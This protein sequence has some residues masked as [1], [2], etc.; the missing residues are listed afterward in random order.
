VLVNILTFLGCMLLNANLALL[1]P[2]LDLLSG[3]AFRADPADSARSLRSRFEGRELLIVSA[4]PR[5]TRIAIARTEPDATWHLGHI[6]EID[7]PAGFTSA[8]TQVTACIQALRKVARPAAA[9]LCLSHSWTAT[10][11]GPGTPAVDLP[12]MCEE[13][14]PFIDLPL[15]HPVLP[16]RL[17]LRID[18]SIVLQSHAALA[19]AGL[20]I[21]RI[22]IAT[23]A[24]LE[25]ICIRAG[26]DL[27][28]LD[29]LAS[30]G[31]SA[32][33]IECTDGPWTSV[34]FCTNRPADLRDDIARFLRDRPSS[35]QLAVLAPDTLHPLIAALHPA[36]VFDLLPAHPH[37]DL[38]ACLEY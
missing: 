4:A 35:G 13:P 12:P 28:G 37:A 14:G 36:A 9:V 5:S 11:D 8:S 1:R 25:Q 34:R 15:P 2:M 22:R 16:G 3:G 7:T 23:A 33:L 6:Q 27:I 19:H 30:D 17:N 31:A 10:I 20:P 29:L 21:A 26:R 24:L 38:I 18:E 32:L